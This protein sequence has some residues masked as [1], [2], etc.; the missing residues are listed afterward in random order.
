MTIKAIVRVILSGYLTNLIFVFLTLRVSLQRLHFNKNKTFLQSWFTGPLWISKTL[1][2]AYVVKV[3]VVFMEFESKKVSHMVHMF[4]SPKLADS[5]PTKQ[6]F[7][8]LLFRNPITS[9]LGNADV[10]YLDLITYSVLL[11][12][13]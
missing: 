2:N 7:K 1:C 11:L 3:V 10:L 13:V 9:L 5:A 4:H 8:F 12:D 6:F